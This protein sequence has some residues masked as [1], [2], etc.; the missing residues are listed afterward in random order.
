[1]INPKSILLN[2]LR[3]KC[4][5]EKRMIVAAA[6]AAATHPDERRLDPCQLAGPHPRCDPQ[7]AGD[8]H[9]RRNRGLDLVGVV[10]IGEE[11]TENRKAIEHYGQVSVVGWIPPLQTIDRPA[12][13]DTFEVHFAKEHFR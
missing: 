12:L 2:K 6:V 1:M 4:D 11:N 5:F 9:G 8:Q 7:R 13:L 10:M 3:S